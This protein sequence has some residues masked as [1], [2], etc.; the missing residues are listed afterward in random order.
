MAQFDRNRWR[1]HSEIA[2]EWL[3]KS[4][5]Y[6]LAVQHVISEIRS[7]RDSLQLDTNWIN[8]LNEDDVI[9]L[10]LRVVGFV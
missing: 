2:T 8:K 3:L 5:N 7:S 4:H 6:G 1:H 10:A 9:L